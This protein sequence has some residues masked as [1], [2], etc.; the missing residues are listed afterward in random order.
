MFTR[1]HSK[2]YSFLPTAKSN[3]SHFSEFSRAELQ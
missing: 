2:L 1:R 3:P